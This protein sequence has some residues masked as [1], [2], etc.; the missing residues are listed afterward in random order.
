ML[1]T[2][3]LNLISR[4]AL[5]T[6]IYP[7]WL[8]TKT[9]WHVGTCIIELLT[10]QTIWHVWYMY[11]WAVGCTLHQWD[12]SSLNTVRFIYIKINFK[13]VPKQNT[14]D[15]S[16]QAGL[17]Q[18]IYIKVLKHVSVWKR[19]KSVYSFISEQTNWL[20]LVNKWIHMISHE[21]FGSIY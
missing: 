18:T 9:I 13:S 1:T 5:Y 10:A 16:I 12:N 21:F 11:N 19:G 8:L 2:F 14:L 15:D 4:R 17:L 20:N 7:I 6:F 3:H